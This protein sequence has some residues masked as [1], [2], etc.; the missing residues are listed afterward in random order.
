MKTIGKSSYDLDDRTDLINLLHSENAP[1][2]EDL[3]AAPPISSTE[4][5]DEEETI[6]TFL[7]LDVESGL[8]IM[9]EK[10]K[11]VFYRVCGYVLFKLFKESHVLSECVN[12]LDACSHKGAEPHKY[13]LLLRMTN[14]KENCLFEVSNEVFE[15]L[16]KVEELITAVQPSLSKLKTDVIEF[17]EEKVCTV[18]IPPQLKLDCHPNVAK[19]VIHRYIRFRFRYFS[20]RPSEERKVPHSADMSSLSSGSRYLAKRYKAPVRR[21]RK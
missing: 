7:S 6:L 8:P 19:E 2:P 13:A 5:E 12:C 14:F 15:L 1:I 10:E 11:Y 20:D 21:T 16:V 4:E 18:E 17:L 9:P 3:L